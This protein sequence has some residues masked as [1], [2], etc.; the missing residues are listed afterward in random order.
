MPG[1]TTTPTQAAEV[2]ALRAA[3]LSLMAIAERVSLSVST[4]Q[5]VLQK[6]PT[7]KGAAKT[8][9]IQATRNEMLRRVVNDEAIREEAA[10][11]I[12]DDLA[13]AAML[14][15]KI[16]LA[17]EH[18]DATNLQEAALVMRAAAAYSVAV[19]NTSDTLRRVMGLDRARPEVDEELPELVVRE[20]RPEEVTALRPPMVAADDRDV[21]EP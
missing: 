5:R 12:A 8:A 7:S 10:R 11:L 18:M 15:R 21:T 6:H 2:I 9:L 16:G 3:G 1:I 20:L 17:A 19:K 14:R 13:H 4:V